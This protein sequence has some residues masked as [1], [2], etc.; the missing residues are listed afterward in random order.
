MSTKT[1]LINNN[2]KL[3]SNNKKLMAIKMLNYIGGF[4][5]YK[6]KV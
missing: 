5:G 6:R 4:Y 1:K 3:N 2:Q